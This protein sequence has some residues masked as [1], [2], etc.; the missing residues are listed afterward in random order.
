MAWDAIVL[1]LV[2]PLLFASFVLA[3][4]GVSGA[5]PLRVLG[6]LAMTACQGVPL[7]WRRRR[8]ESATG[9]VAVGH[10]VQL[11][12]VDT[13][14]PGNVTVLLM[15]YALGRYARNRRLARAY[16]V[17]AAIGGLVGGVDWTWSDG[18]TP[19]DPIVY[20]VVTSIWNVLCALTPW[21]F[22]LLARQRELSVRQLRDR[23]EALERERD[24]R[25]RLAAEEERTRIAREM[26]DV[27][28]HSLSVIVVQADG[29]AYAVG[30]GG[31][32]PVGVAE[33]AL[34]TIGSTAREALADTRRLVSVLRGHESGGPEYRPRGGLSDLASLVDP[35]VAAGRDVRVDVTED[36][37]TVPRDADLAAYRVVQESLTNV[38]KHAGPG[39][40]VRVGVTYAPDTLC[41]RVADDGRGAA[42]GDDGAGHGLIGMRERVTAYGGTL[43]A[44]PVPG[45]YVVTARIPL[46]DDASAHLEPGARP[47][48]D[49]PEP[50]LD[51]EPDPDP[52]DP[53]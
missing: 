47:E 34:A 38:I 40:A 30:A 41:V 4:E 16:L 33:R 19:A 13:P 22:G 28:A 18:F 10:L 3:A 17:L 26:H 37:V 7:L 39:A 8:P 6:A 53:R 11:F 45:G 49:H 29:A 51:P 42:A 27:V 12:L 50:N 20:L 23:A 21:A 32:D 1:A 9:V 5:T 2:S 48:P 25:A 46:R 44:G 31:P 24:Q 15:T 35:L 14:L 52:G 43:T 36:P